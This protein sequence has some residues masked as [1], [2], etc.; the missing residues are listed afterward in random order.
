MAEL[1]FVY[2][3]GVYN[4]DPNTNGLT[5]IKTP[6]KYKERAASTPGR[7]GGYSAAALMDARVISAKGSLFATDS[8]T[9]RS[10]KDAFYA[11]HAPGPAQ[12]LLLNGDR[13]I[14]CQVNGLDE[15]EYEGLDSL[16]YTLSF[17]ADDPY[18][19]DVGVQS[20]NL[21]GSFTPG[22]TALSLPV[23]N[24]VVS[25]A[26]GTITVSNSA[27]GQNFILNPVAVDTYTIDSMAETVTRSGID[28]SAEQGAGSNFLQLVP[29]AVNTISVT[30]AGGAA[31][32]SVSSTYQN[33]WY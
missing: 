21:P 18:F 17:R 16:E 27:T 2:S 14:N 7:D 28:A 11:A 10:L 23:I 31:Y 8:G 33:R 30:V 3:F 19:Y 24:L 32:S 20:P 12:R 9:L 29:N 5:T 4:Y 25:T 15:A 1:S 6:I 26:G 22:G 13:Y